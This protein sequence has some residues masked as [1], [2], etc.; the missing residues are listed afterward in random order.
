MTNASQAEGDIGGN[1]MDSLNAMGTS[2]RDSLSTIVSFVRLEQIVLDILLLSPPIHS[3]SPSTNDGTHIR[4]GSKQ[5]R[6]NVTSNNSASSGVSIGS[7]I[8]GLTGST[9]PAAAVSGTNA[10]AGTITGL[11]NMLT[12]KEAKKPELNCPAH[13][14]QGKTVSASIPTA[15]RLMTYL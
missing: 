3:E 4:G 5:L 14:L 7:I 6:H 2:L 9:N 11:M 1:S 10:I 8:T 13:I 15:I 12:V